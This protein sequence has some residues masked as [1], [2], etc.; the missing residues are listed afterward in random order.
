[1]FNMVTIITIIICHIT[2]VTITITDVIFLIIAAM[3]T[4]MITT[5]P[6]LLLSFVLEP[7]TTKTT[8]SRGPNSRTETGPTGPFAS[9]M[10]LAEPQRFPATRVYLDPGL[11]E[12]V[13]LT[14]T[15]RL[16]MAQKPYIVWSLGPKA[17]IYE[18]LKP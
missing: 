13:S 16:K 8:Q 2:I 11:W 4:A 10:W 5:L 7:P 12:C 18:S 17:L 15:L 1:M 9:S 3:S 6:V 14:L